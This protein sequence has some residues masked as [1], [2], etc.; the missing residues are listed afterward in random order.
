MQIKRAIA[1][2][3][4]YTLKSLGYTNAFSPAL[5]WAAG[6][7][8]T[9]GNGSGL[10][11]YDN[12]IVYSGINLLCKKLTEVPIL[13]NQV[14]NKKALKSY[15]KANNPNKLAFTKAKALTELEDHPLID[16]L[17]KPNSYQTG[18]ELMDH[19]WHNYIY[20][21][22]YIIAMA[23]DGEP[24]ADSRRFQPKELH[25]I[26][27]DRVMPQRS[28]D[29][30][31]KISSYV[32]NLN[33]GENITVYPDQVLHMSK[34][35]PSDNELTG[36]GFMNVAGITVSK[37]NA[38]EVAQGSAYKNGGRGTLFSSDWTNGAEPTQKMSAD[39]AAAL[40]K[41]IVD[42]Y[43]G[44]HNNKRLHFTNGYV[45]VQSFGDT[46]AEMEIIE[47]GK[48]NWKDIYTIL[49]IPIAFTP[50]NESLTDATNALVANKQLVTGACL[51]EIRKFDQKF[52]QWIQP[53]YGTQIY[54]CH[55]V[56]EYAELQPDYKMLK[57]TYGDAPYLT[58][59]EKRKLFNFDTDDKTEGMNKYF[60]PSGLIPLDDLMSQDFNQLDNGED[61]GKQYDYN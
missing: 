45:N 18:I 15:L 22:G 35:N 5:M 32:I 16:L 2:L 58:P 46:L 21:D 20:G 7:A 40:K 47:A 1:S 3:A 50:G 17:N 60:F 54:I 39:Q 24:G 49:G 61:T 10:T 37:D 23:G 9:W 30:F 44:A 8:F 13:V 42:D 57:E 52:T 19:F 33:N 29:R 11:N 43:A 53:W 12:K 4:T 36:Y 14:E 6:N 31:R 51:P 59:N 27:R 26:N 34:W 28:N 56:T 41:T 48:S 25:S 55:D 38:G